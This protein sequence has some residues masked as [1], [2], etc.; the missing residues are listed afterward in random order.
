MA[1]VQRFGYYIKGNKLALVEKDTAFDN[2]V[3]SKEY[4][5]GSEYVQWKSPLE[6]SADGIELEYVY[7]PEYFLSSTNTSNTALTHHSGTSDGF[8]KLYDATSTYQNWD[9]ILDVDSYFVLKNAGKFNGL[10]QVSGFET[11]TS[12][13]D[14]I[15]TKTKH[16]A[17]SATPVAFE[18]TVTLYYNVD[19]LNN[20]E[21]TIN[22]SSYLI[23]ALVYYVKAKIAEDA[24]NIEAK[25]YF[26]SEF[27]K[28]VEKFN[29]T[30]GAGLRIQSAGPQ[31]IR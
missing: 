24:M 8:L 28:M 27:R 9:S 3:N 10:H 23:K 2:D 21:D 5:P 18:K 26:M 31:A 17:S 4:G 6:D 25:E 13:N 30:R 11:T 14:T 20:E 1:S 29:N 12:T 22:I 15:V 19:V 16:S 7:S